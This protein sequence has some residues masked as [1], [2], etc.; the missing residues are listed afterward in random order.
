MQR[1]REQVAGAFVWTAVGL[2]AV[3]LAIHLP[4]LGRSLLLWS[5][6]LGAFFGQ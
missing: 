3:Y 1:E 6:L 5:E 4:M 2:A